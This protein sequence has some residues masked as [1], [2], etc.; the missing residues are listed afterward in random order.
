MAELQFIADDNPRKKVVANKTGKSHNHISGGESRMA[1]RKKA[2][3]SVRVKSKKKAKHKPKHRPKAKKHKA[4]KKHSA[5]KHR[6]SAKRKNPQIASVYGTRPKSPFIGGKAK[7]TLLGRK[8]VTTAKD[9]A[10]FDKKLARM[11]AALATAKGPAKKHLEKML[12]GMSTTKDKIGAN[13]FADTKGLESLKASGYKVK[14]GRWSSKHLGQ[15]KRK[16][17]VSEIVKAKRRKA[18]AARKVDKTLSKAFRSLKAKDLALS[19]PKKGS[20]MAKK[21]KHGKKTYSAMLSRVNP[22]AALEIATAGHGTAEFIAVGLGAIAALSPQL[23]ALV[24]GIKGPVAKANEK[25]SALPVVGKVFGPQTPAAILLPLL[26]LAG[27]MADKKG[28]K[29]GKHLES[30]AKGGYAAV[31][32][33]VLMRWISQVAK[34]NPGLSGIVTSE[35]MGDADF[36]REVDFGETIDIQ[37]LGEDIQVG[38]EESAQFDTETPI[39]VGASADFGGVMQFPQGMNGIIATPQLGYTQNDQEMSDDDTISIGETVSIG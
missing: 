35:M 5:K 33:I 20:H 7:R 27:S 39:Q 17:K 29:W 38:A 13:A 4:K 26:H 3:A 23:L 10:Y 34:I 2:K 24:P 16:T 31:A 9:V 19:L 12:T 30:F 28:Q 37:G 32:A 14:L 18:K 11:Q 6:K 15:E 22:S 36:G 1:K 21:R 25:L 8:R